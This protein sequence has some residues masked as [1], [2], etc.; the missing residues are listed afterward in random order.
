MKLVTQTITQLLR[1]LQAIEVD[2]Q[3]DTARAVISKLV[4]MPRRR[5][6]SLRDVSD[7]LESNFEEGSLIL[8]L[9]LGLSKDDYTSRL[10]TRLGD[11]GAGVKKFQTAPD[12]YLNALSELGIL[13]AM[14]V[15]VN[16]KPHWSDVLVERLRSGRGSAI[17]GQKRGRGVEDLAEAVIKEVFGNRYA[18]RCNFIGARGI[19]AK[20]DFAIPSKTEPRIVVEAKAYGA[21]GSKMTD[22]IGDIEKI[23]SAK[24][25]DTAFLF[26]TDGLPWRQRESDLRKIVHY[27]NQGDI[28][29]IYTLATLPEMGTDLLTLKD[30]FGL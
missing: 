26:F 1:S 3:D 25:Q 5:E 22:I 20:C 23:I 7:I 13:D 9:F 14:S 16:R 10:R 21:T 11:G 17:S 2:W 29:R 24:R 19:E 12:E 4:T 30:E 6:Y 18:K 27:Q 8:R 15:E 28:T